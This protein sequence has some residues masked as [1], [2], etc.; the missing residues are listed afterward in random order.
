MSSKKIPVYLLNPETLAIVF[1]FTSLK[2]AAKFLNVTKQAVH[3]AFLKGYR[4]QGFII[5]TQHDHNSK[6]L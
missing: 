5:V 4:C 2:D 3:D 1:E 6:G